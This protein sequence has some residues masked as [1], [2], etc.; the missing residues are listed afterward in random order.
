MVDEF[1]NIT[2]LTQSVCECVHMCVHPYTDAYLQ[3]AYW[4]YEVQQKPKQH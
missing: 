3:Q 1:Y 4:N 2:A